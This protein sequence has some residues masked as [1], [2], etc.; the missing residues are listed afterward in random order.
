MKC[1]TPNTIKHPTLG[2]IAVPCGNC[3]I[4]QRNV[5]SDWATRLRYEAEASKKVYFVRLSYDDEHLPR[6]ELYLPT[7]CKAD[8]QK[9][10]K[11]VRKLI[12]FRY[13]AVG[14]YGSKFGRPHYHVLFFL[15]DNIEW[16]PFRNILYKCWY[17]Q[18]IHVESARDYV[19]LAYYTGKYCF[20][21]DNRSDDSQVKPFRTCSKKPILGYLYLQKFGAFH[22]SNSNYRY[23]SVESTKDRVKRL[24]LAFQRKLFKNDNQAVITARSLVNQ[25]NHKDYEFIKYL[26]NHSGS[27][28]DDLSSIRVNLRHQAINYAQI[29]E[30][31]E[32]TRVNNKDLDL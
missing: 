20:K 30:Q 27:I 19:R 9:F 18:N 5:I 32:R 3:I 22:L 2:Y 4:C 6:N 16:L 7:L 13:F 31:R 29:E 8:L 24:P 23:I 14:E 10:F 25:L 15:S 1:P 26:K 12:S 17:K 11:R 21:N 28:P